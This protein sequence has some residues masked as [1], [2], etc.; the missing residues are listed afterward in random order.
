M[1]D[2]ENKKWEKEKKI[3]DNH[4]QIIFKSNELLDNEVTLIMFLFFYTNCVD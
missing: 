3:N 4:E 1:R 2:F